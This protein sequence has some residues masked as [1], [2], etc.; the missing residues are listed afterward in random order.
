[1]TGLHPPVVSA[2]RIADAAT[3]STTPH[4]SAVVPAT[5]IATPMGSGCAVNAGTKYVSD[6]M[7]ALASSVR[8][9]PRRRSTGAAI[10]VPT[11]L[12]TPNSARNT[13]Y[14]AAPRPIGPRAKSANTEEN[15]I[16]AKLLSATI[17]VKTRWSGWPA[18]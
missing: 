5:T 14:P 3:R 4:V 6:P 16:A 11:R 12:P 18:R 15:A 8:A 7:N 17:V 13:P 10:V 9:V 1:M 2:A